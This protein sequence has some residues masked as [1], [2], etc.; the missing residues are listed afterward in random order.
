MQTEKEILNAQTF[1]RTLKR[2][3]HEIIEN[4]ED[5]ENVA[6]VG[7]L[8]RGATLADLLGEI[9]KEIS[10]VCLPI[11]YIDITPYRDDLHEKEIPSVIETEINFDIESKTIILIDD[12]IF[13]GR[14]VRAAMDALIDMGRPAKIRLC[15]MVDRGHRELPIRPDYIGKNVPTS[16]SESVKV[17]VEAID[18]EY[19]VR[20]LK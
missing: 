20:L 12:V 14:T 2:L 16:I 8:R 5:L 15:E 17:M 19:A 7:I 1:M 6:L 11:G 9:I 3:A 18:G 13:H 10:D 4:N